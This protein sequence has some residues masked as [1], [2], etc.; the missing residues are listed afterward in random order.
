MWAWNYKNFKDFFV[1]STWELDVNGTVGHK[2][3]KFWFKR[4]HPNRSWQMHLSCVGYVILQYIF[5][6]IIK[7]TLRAGKCKWAWF[8]HI[9][10]LRSFPEWEPLRRHPMVNTIKNNYFR[11]NF[12]VQPLPEI[13][14]PELQPNWWTS[15]LSRCWKITECE[16]PHWVRILRWTRRTS[17]AIKP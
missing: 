2:A 5:A 6:K 8:L 10:C 17:V 13:S 11:R 4:F 3:I 9:I 1:V 15:L 7:D 14:S 12:Q 16:C